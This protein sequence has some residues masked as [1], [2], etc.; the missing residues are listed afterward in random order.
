MDIPQKKLRFSK[1]LDDPEFE[2]VIKGYLSVEVEDIT[3]CYF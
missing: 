2:F 3:I 1:N